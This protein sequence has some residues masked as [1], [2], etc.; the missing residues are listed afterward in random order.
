MP[1]SIRGPVTLATSIYGA[2]N[3]IYLMLDEPELAKRLGV[4]ITDVV[5]KMTQAMDKET[6]FKSGFSFYDDNCCLL[7]PQMYDFFAFPILQKVFEVRSPNNTDIRYQ[8]SDSSMG[9]LL[10]ILGRLNL[11]GCNFGPDVLFDQIR[12]HMPDTRVDGCLSPLVFMD[13]DEDE[14]HKTNKEGL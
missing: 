3:F 9:H 5:L 2:Q 14:Y 4:T 7:T 11:T 10:P 12:K 6:G 8:H 13:N 1:R